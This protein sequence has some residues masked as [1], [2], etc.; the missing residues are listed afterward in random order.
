MQHETAIGLDR[1]AETDPEISDIGPVQLDIDLAEKTGQR[2]AEGTVDDDAHRAL[3][4]VLADE[5]QRTRKDRIG[6]AGHGNQELA[7]EIHLHVRIIA[8]DKPITTSASD[9]V[10][11][12][13]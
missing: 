11:I 5:G 2:H 9:R 6:K 8:H 4:A 7:G 10:K 3:L 1:P 13:Q 12:M